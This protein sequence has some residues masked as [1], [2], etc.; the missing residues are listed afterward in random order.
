MAMRKTNRMD[1]GSRRPFLWGMAHAFDL[2]ALLL[3]SRDRLLRGPAADAA[4]LRKD[5]LA[6]M[7]RAERHAG[8]P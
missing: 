1:S 3:P 6:A 5:W 8:K 7:G 4:A 2:G